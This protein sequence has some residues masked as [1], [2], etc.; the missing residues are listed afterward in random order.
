M[1]DVISVLN[2]INNELGG[3]VIT[4][5]EYV[6]MLRSL[7]K[8]KFIGNAMFWFEEVRKSDDGGIKWLELNYKRMDSISFDPI[9]LIEGEDGY[10]Y[11]EDKYIPLMMQRYGFL[12]RTI[13][14]KPKTDV[15]V[16]NVILMKLWFA[17]HKPDHK[18]CG[19]DMSN[20]S[21]AIILKANTVDRITHPDKFADF[22]ISWMK[23]HT[24][25]IEKTMKMRGVDY[26]AEIV[27]ALA[28]TI[29][30]IL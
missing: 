12:A 23:E 24:D 7:T 30:K 1:A 5:K 3:E 9:K 27:A 14:E 10:A 25:H 4:I 2:R 21:G 6:G 15:S 26:E 11:I 8:P 16:Y 18:V 13:K 22:C 20:A 19:I 28:D 17:K 29:E